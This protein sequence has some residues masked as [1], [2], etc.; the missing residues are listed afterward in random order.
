MN[1]EYPK[2]DYLRKQS[3]V[4]NSLEV[5]MNGFKDLIKDKI[6]P[7]NK[8]KAYEDNTIDILNRLLVEANDLDRTNPG[9]GIFSLIVLCLRT[10]LKLRDLMVE[11]EHKIK[12][13]EIRIK[14]IN[15]N[16]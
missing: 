13:L 11:Q 2:N 4:R 6:H 14:K 16:G 12:E 15:R 8:S 5:A 7:K 10:N 3:L 1:I 9:E